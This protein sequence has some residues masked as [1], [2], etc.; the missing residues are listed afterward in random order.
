MRQNRFSINLT[1]LRRKAGLTQLK[2]SVAA[3]LS[4]SMVQLYE[5]DRRTPGL[6]SLIKL[7]DTLNVS[8]DE[9]V[10]GPHNPNTNT[11]SERNPI[12]DGQ[13]LDI[14]RP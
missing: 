2:L 8:L 11:R 13:R 1:L 6:V 5:S 7:A 9:L 14:Q 10:H 12:S 4:C 3:G